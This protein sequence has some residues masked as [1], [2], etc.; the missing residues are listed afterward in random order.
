VVRHGRHRVVAELRQTP[1]LPAIDRW[2]DLLARELGLPRSLVRAEAVTTPC[3][4][5]APRLDDHELLVV[6]LAGRQRWTLRPLATPESAE[7]VELA[8]GSVLFVPRT[9]WRSAERIG[10]A[11]S[12]ALRVSLHAPSW[13][14]LLDA[15]LPALLDRSSEWRQPALDLWETAPGAPLILIEQLTTRLAQLADGLRDI[16]SEVVATALRGG[17]EK[18]VGLF[19]RKRDLTA[20]RVES[21]L[22][23]SAAPLVRWLTSDRRI[24]FGRQQAA[25]VVG[26]DGAE[27]DR[28]LE[29]LVDLGY[30]VICGARPAR[31]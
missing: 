29:R 5:P 2:C 18:P 15:L 3:A 19:Y 11:P 28:L 26:L 16:E 27:V 8:P 14:A 30:L 12:L 6:Q 7:T 21:R 10:R 31:H 24:T 9:H 22:P 25:A 17:A 13:R 20:L 4:G 1:A 23:T